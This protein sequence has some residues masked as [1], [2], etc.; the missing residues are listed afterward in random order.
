LAFPGGKVSTLGGGQ[1]LTS[2]RLEKGLRRRKVTAEVTFGLLE[3]GIKTRSEREKKKIEKNLPVRSDS[4]P[5]KKLA[6]VGESGGGDNVLFIVPPRSDNVRGRAKTRF[7]E[8]TL[9][10]SVVFLSN[11]LSNDEAK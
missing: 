10:E 3:K 7:L 5:S 8:G 11:T 6:K 9:V 2:G 1:G 4:R